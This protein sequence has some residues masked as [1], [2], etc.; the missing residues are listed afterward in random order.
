RVADVIAA[1]TAV[2]ASAI[3]GWRTPA[4][5]PGR[6]TV[7]GAWATYIG[8]FV[9]LTV[10]ETPLVHVV[11][12]AAGATTAAWIASALSIYGAL[13]LVGDLHALRHGGVMV[14]TE[15]VDVRVGIRWR[16]RIPRASIARVERGRAPDGAC[17]LSILGAEV[18]LELTEPV[19]VRG[20]FGRRRDACVLAVSADDPD[21]L[22]A[23]IA[24]PPLPE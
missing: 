6:F 18:V 2:V 7:H 11:L 22:V 9:A 4:R 21:G 1:E 17:D 10:V 12:V 24:A 13:W 8:V 20:L 14:T 16:A 15:W 3:T 5:S 19:A 23:A